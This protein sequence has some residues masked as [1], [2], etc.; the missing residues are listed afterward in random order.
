MFFHYLDYL[1]GPQREMVTSPVCARVPRVDCYPRRPFP[2]LR[3]EGF[4]RA[5]LRGEEGGDC[6]WDIM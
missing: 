3:G 4:E 2:S 1:V 5:G 6:Y